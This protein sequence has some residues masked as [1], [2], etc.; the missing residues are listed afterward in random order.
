MSGLAGCTPPRESCCVTEVPDPP[1]LE[2]GEHGR[3][4]GGGL[5]GRAAR[6]ATEQET[7]ERDAER[8][9][10]R[11]HGTSLRN[12][13][14]GEKA[15]PRRGT[16]ARPPGVYILEAFPCTRSPPSWPSCSRSR[17]R[18]PR[19]SSCHATPRPCFGPRA[20]RRGSSS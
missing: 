17:R 9:R 15:S 5:G 18:P 10:T 12:G 19:R 4:I 3:V 20:G 7:R 1:P 2:A 14:D 13:G 11:G 8:Q 6:R 16:Q